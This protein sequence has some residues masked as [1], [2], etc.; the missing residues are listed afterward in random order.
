[1]KNFVEKNYSLINKTLF[2]ITL[3]FGLVPLIFN[4][5]KILEY[6]LYQI[7]I[8][9][10]LLTEICDLIVSYDT[11]SLN[12]LRLNLYSKI[13]TP[14]FVLY[15]IFLIYTL[16]FTNI[17]SLDFYNY[18]SYV[19]FAYAFV[20]TYVRVKFDKYYLYRLLKR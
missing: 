16:N 1:M 11:I 13:V 5:N 6:N 12:I 3:I 20:L 19:S 14:I 15:N 10:F 4:I 2:G 8:L 17:F 9:S 18:S 7:M